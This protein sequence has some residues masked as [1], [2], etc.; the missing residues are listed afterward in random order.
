MDSISVHC[1]HLLHVLAT[2]VEQELEE[3]YPEELSRI[4]LHKTM[5]QRPNVRAR[6][7]ARKL[8]VHKYTHLTPMQRYERAQAHSQLLP[9]ALRLAD[10]LILGS[11]LDLSRTAV[12]VRSNPSNCDCYM[13]A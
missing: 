7:R 11:M 3:A 8:M 12:D 10:F 9:R 6:C 5:F 4:P 1:Q 13:F 2:D